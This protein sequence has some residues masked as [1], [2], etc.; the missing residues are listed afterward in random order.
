MDLHPGRQ[1]I[2]LA[3]L[4]I[5]ASTFV[6]FSGALNNDFIG[7]DDEFYVL[8]NPYITPLSPTMVWQMFSHVY[9]NS[10]TPLTLLSH[11]V[12][13]KL[14]G[15][16]SR[17]HHLTNIVLHSLNAVWVFILSLAILR[18][19]RRRLSPD[20]VTTAGEEETTLE[21]AI[22]IGAVVSALSFACLPLRVESVASVSSR[23]DLLSAFFA[24]P[25][26]LTF[27]VYA[28]RRGRAGAGRWYAVSLGLFALALIAKG[29]VMTLAGLLLIL[30]LITA[31]V[32]GGRRRWWRLFREIV[33][34]LLVGLAAAIVAYGASEQA[35]S[36][37]QVIRAQANV[38]RT[39][40]GFYHISFY[41]IKTVWPV[42]LAAL[43]TYP[44]QPGFLLTWLMTP[45]LTLGCAILWWKGHRSWLFAWSAYLVALLP[46]AG[47]VPSSIQLLTNRYVYFAAT[48]FALLMGGGVTSAW[49]CM[50]NRQRRGVFIA[51]LAV[52]V[53]A[54]LLAQG[55]LTVLDIRDWRDE[56]TLWRHTLLVSPNHALAHNEMGLALR[57]KEDYAGAVNSFKRAI[58]IQPRF[59]EA[60]TNLGSAYLAQGDTAGAE[61]VLRASLAIDPRNYA[62]FTNMGNLRLIERRFENAATWYRQSLA[63]KPKSYEAMYNLGYAIL[64]MGKYDEALETLSRAIALNPNSRDAWFLTGQI[65]QKRDEVRS[66]EAYRQA[67]RLGHT[68]SQQ[69]LAGRGMN[70]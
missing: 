61:R 65:L 41:V 40:L 17:G 46:M 60:L 51:A 68:Q 25:S 55:A 3:A 24:F 9:F 20:P 64:L 33:P 49:A 31:G 57:A 4:L 66:L 23:K 67:A 35:G 27:M 29:S 52:S 50:Q 2:I 38:N 63:V 19:Y 44:P 11:A 58:E 47:F 15:M 62:V 26:L 7:W 13:Y 22:L 34:F 16:D 56:V 54:I 30:D 6:L 1:R 48:P 59:P 37:A 36:I 53:S 5:A 10:W 69:I 39:E 28:A 42:D 32:G 70:W 8:T 43:Y 45:V 12:D 18:A 14:W 21:T